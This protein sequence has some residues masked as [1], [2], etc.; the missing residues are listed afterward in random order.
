VH[1]VTAR[2]IAEEKIFRDTG[3][4]VTGI[5]ILAGLCRDGLLVC[6]QFC[7]MPTH[8]HVLGTFDD[9]SKAIHKLNRRYAISYN[10]RY[11]RRGH[12]FDS[13]Y[14]ALPIETEKHFFNVTRYIALNPPNHETW[15]YSSYPGLIGTRSSHPFVDPAPIIAAYES[16]E[17]FRQA[18]RHSREAEDA[19]LVPAFAGNQVQSRR[20]MTSPPCDSPTRVKPLRS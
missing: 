6:H 13:P 1:H 15:S 3:D 5:S 10:K 7:F 17:Q 2:S 4:Y 18:V 8:Y 11:G 19:N 12:V 9:V 20:D 16:P 14:R